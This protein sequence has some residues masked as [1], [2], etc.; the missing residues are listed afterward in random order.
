MAPLLLFLPLPSLL[1]A[2]EKLF[3]NQPDL[4]GV[5]D[6][7]FDL[8]LDVDDR[9][10][11][12]PESLTISDVEFCRIIA[13][14]FSEILRINYLILKCKKGQIILILLRGSIICLTMFHKSSIYAT[15]FVQINVPSEFIEFKIF[16][17]RCG[18]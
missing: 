5:P 6:D 3:L 9:P 4:L 1:N 11:S 2:L 14:P 18:S 8:E 7:L 16:F 15:L 13:A 17:L 10:P 12:S